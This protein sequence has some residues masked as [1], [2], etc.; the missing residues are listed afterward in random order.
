MREV[1]G[2]GLGVLRGSAKMRGARLNVVK[3]STKVDV[4]ELSKSERWLIK[5]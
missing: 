5:D 4:A 3:G 2:A 1:G